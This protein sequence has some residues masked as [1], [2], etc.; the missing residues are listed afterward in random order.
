MTIGD[1]ARRKLE[2]KSFQA[3]LQAWA[4]VD[5]MKKAEEKLQDVPGTQRVA[6]DAKFAEANAQPLKAI[7]AAA[8]DLLARYPQSRAVAPARTI[9]ERYKIRLAGNK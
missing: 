3:Q 5:E 4:R 2:D 7:A 8:A 9:L 1:V 6:G